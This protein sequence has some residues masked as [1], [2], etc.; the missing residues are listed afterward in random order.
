MKWPKLAW[1]LRFIPI[2]VELTCSKR[3][4][5][6]GI[7]QIVIPNGINLQGVNMEFEQLFANA[8]Q[9]RTLNQAAKDWGVPY[10]NLQRYSKAE[11]VPDYQTALILA[12]EAGVSPGEVMQILARLEARK[13]PRSLFPDM[14]FRLQTGFVQTPLLTALSLMGSIVTVCIM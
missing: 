2:G 6:N 4:I 10:T 13:K 11:R 8:L 3:V 9:G 7:K 14:A 1:R 5:P 12:A